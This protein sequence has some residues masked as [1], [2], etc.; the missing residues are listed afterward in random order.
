VPR[1]LHLVVGVDRLRR[2]VGGVTRLAGVAVG[3]VRY[4]VPPF[5]HADDRRVF[6]ADDVGELR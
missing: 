5:H 4:L 3:A 6:C 2:R 1:P